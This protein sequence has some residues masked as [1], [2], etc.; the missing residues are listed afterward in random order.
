MQTSLNLIDSQP[1][2]LIVLSALCLFSEKSASVAQLENR[3]VLDT[4]DIEDALSFLEEH[5]YIIVS[6][7]DV[8]YITEKGLQYVNEKTYSDFKLR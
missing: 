8:N 2:A 6:A 3:T 4:D 7:N 5:S 1:K